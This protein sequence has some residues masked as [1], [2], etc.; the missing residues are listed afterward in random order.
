MRYFLIANELET[1][2]NKVKY[3]RKIKNKNLHKKEK[4]LSNTTP[5]DSY[6]DTIYLTDNEKE[7]DELLAAGAIEQT[8]AQYLEWVRVKN[9]ILKAQ[10]EQMK[11]D[12][13]LI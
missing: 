7:C 9:E 12:E 5:A 13:L 10:E 2:Q 1:T 8:E 4:I 11:E 6:V 3:K